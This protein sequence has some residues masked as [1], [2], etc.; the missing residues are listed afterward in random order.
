[1]VTPRHLLILVGLFLALASHFPVGAQVQS[2]E[3]RLG[4]GDTV[5]VLV[6]QH[7]DLTLETRVSENGTISYPLIGSVRIGGM[8]IGAGEQSI[9]RALRDGGFIKQP[10]VNILLLQSRGNQVSVLGQVGKPGRYPLET[11]NTK[12]SEMLAIAGGVAPTGADI[13]I[14]TGIRDGNPFRKEIDIAALFLRNSP[15]EDIIVNG[16]DVIFVNRAPTYYVYGEVQKPGSY[17]VERGMTVRQALAQGGGLTARGTERGLRLYRRG[18]NGSVETLT[19]SLDDLVQPDD[20]F[21][22]RE[23]LF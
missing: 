10:R 1:M 15:Q 12:L 3:Y 19:P 21:H 9:A 5:R 20:V 22:V 4:P 17:R 6:F 2:N 14:V 23:S 7:P 11:S 13:A 8:T 18:A 16:G